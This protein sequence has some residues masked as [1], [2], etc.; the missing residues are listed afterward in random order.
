MGPVYLAIYAHTFVA[1]P[2]EKFVFYLTMI[3]AV[4][5]VKNRLLTQGFSLMFAGNFIF[6]VLKITVLTKVGLLSETV[7]SC[8]NVLTALAENFLTRIIFTLNFC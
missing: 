1:L 6:V 3:L 2:T 4:T 5:K 7:M 8:Q